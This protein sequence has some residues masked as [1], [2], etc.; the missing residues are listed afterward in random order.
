MTSKKH[1]R[2][3]DRCGEALKKYER[4]KKDSKKGWGNNRPSRKSGQK[5]KTSR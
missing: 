4:S 5:T 1:Q 3:S 2:A